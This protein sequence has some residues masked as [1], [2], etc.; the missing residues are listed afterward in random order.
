MPRLTLILLTLAALLPIQAAAQQVRMVTIPAGSFEP[1]YG[2]VGEPPVKVSAFRLDERPV[3]RGEYQQF[4][5]DNPKW[6]RDSVSRIFADAGYLRSWK[7]AHSAGDDATLRQPVTQVSWFAARAYCEAQGKRLP[8]TEE[9]EYVGAASE[10]LRDASRDSASVRELLKVYTVGRK[11]HMPDAG[12]GARN[13][14]GVRD[15]HGLVWEHVENFNSII[16]SDDSRGTAGSA[17]RDHQ[18][19]CASAAIGAT[20]TENYPAFLRYAVRA[21]L[22][23]STTTGMLGFRCAA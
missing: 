5:L 17:E 23:G 6:Q 22:S 11:G 4:V 15:M 8:T 3:T 2:V 19:W 7:S 16:A 13:Y 18:L 14:Y 12:S 10:T 1:L 20:N 21:S 9:W